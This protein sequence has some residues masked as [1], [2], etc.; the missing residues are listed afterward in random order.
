MHAQN[1]M[2]KTESLR[3]MLEASSKDA[4]A[5]GEIM[6]VIAQS[7]LPFPPGS[8]AFLLGA[9]EHSEE[10]R[11]RHPPDR[12]MGQSILWCLG[13]MQPANLAK[14]STGR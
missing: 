10:L 11:P 1:L 12:R 9:F 14:P 5:C 6:D 7:N 8:E 3:F 2:P 4:Q 13:V